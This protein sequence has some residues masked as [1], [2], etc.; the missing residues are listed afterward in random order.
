MYICIYCGRCAMC[1]THARW[2]MKGVESGLQKLQKHEA[3]DGTFLSFLKF[4]CWCQSLRNYTY[5]YTY[6]YPDADWYTYNIMYTCTCAYIDAHAYVYIYICIA[7]YS[8][9]ILSKNIYIYIIYIYIYIY[10]YP[11]Y[12]ICR[13][14]KSATAMESPVVA[15]SLPGSSTRWNRSSGRCFSWRW[16]CDLSRAERN[17]KLTLGGW[18]IGIY[19][20]GIMMGNL[21]IVY[22]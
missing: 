19:P 16:S 5:T 3:S 13:A 15:L 6:P 2:N 4:F 7:L 1:S 18:T 22:D 20:D 10:I 17:G 14:Y 9:N 11:Y 21:Y 12:T 8:Y